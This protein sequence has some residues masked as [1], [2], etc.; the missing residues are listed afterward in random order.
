MYRKI[1]IA[2]DGSES[3]RIALEEALLLAAG[4]R[5]EAHVIHVY[6]PLRPM[7]MQG[8]AELPRLLREEGEH[9]LEHAAERARAMGVQA[10]TATVD[11]SGR[12]TA[13]AI[14]AEAIASGADLIAIGT[15]GRRGV[16]RML[17]GSVAES[18][19]RHATVP[20][21]LIR[22]RAGSLDGGK[23]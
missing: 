15:H 8:M 22:E 6:E 19:A 10:T 16:Q 5:A 20:V 21:L 3:S 17:L 14:V 2:T 11:A 13:D 23:R 7:A 12:P 4:L 9:A 18:V 1:L